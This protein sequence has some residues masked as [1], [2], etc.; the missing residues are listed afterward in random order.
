MLWTI[1]GKKLDGKMQMLVARKCQELINR[2]SSQST[3]SDMR[4][5]YPSINSNVR[6]NVNVAPVVGS[7]VSVPDRNYVP[8][9]RNFQPSTKYRPK[10]GKRNVGPVQ[11]LLTLLEHI[12][13]PACSGILKPSRNMFDRMDQ[14]S[15]SQLLLQT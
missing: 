6:V 8:N 2:Q 4:R 10:N 5:L 14:L 7:S 3:E 13:V 12:F 1:L 9:I 15:Y 11:K